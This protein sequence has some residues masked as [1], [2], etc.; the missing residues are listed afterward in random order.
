MSLPHA[1]RRKRGKEEKKGRGRKEQYKS[2]EGDLSSLAGKCVHSGVT[3]DQQYGPH[4][5]S[6]SVIL[7]PSSRTL[8][9]RK[10]FTPGQ[11]D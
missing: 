2:G 4:V 5:E 7:Y 6:G 9:D 10:I 1:E 11:C 3:V 8:W